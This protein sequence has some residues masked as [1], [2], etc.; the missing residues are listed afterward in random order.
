MLEFAK[1]KEELE[2]FRC[3]DHGKAPVIKLSET[4]FEF[5]D[6]CCDRFRKILDENLSESMVKNMGDIDEEIY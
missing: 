5:T 4:G 2:Q 1:M 6:V 3:P